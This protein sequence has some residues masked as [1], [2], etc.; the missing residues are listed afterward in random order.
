MKTQSS[1]DLLCVGIA[2][3]DLVFQVAHHPEPDEKTNAHGF[4]QCGGGTAAN[5]AVAAARL[6]HR[7]AYAGYLG[8]DLYGQRHVDELEA[9][10]IDTRLIVRGEM[11]TSLSSIYV[12]PDGSRSIVNYKEPMILNPGAVNLD[13]WTA[14]A[15]LFDGHHM[16][17]SLA[18]ADWA[19][20]RGIP[21]VIDADRVHAGSMALAEHM[22]YLV[23]SERFA[24]DFMDKDSPGEAVERLLDLAPHVVIT[25]GERGL[26]WRTRED[27]GHFPAFRVTAI[28]TTGAGDAFHGAFAAGVAAGYAWTDLLAYASATGAL[29]TTVTG[30]RVGMPTKSEL[31]QF[32]EKAR[33]A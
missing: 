3:Y 28:D 14:G 6:G 22:D 24:R 7:V 19:K 29:C 31:A 18:V 20:E 33:G 13:G 11:A 21:T 26:V 8:H 1:V 27:G 10:G 25:L 15:V 30:A 4:I 2:C 5:A 23:A 16:E 17:L 32:L 9:E 12:K